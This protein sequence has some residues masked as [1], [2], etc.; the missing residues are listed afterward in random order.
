MSNS[1]RVVIAGGASDADVRN[2]RNV[3]GLGSILFHGTHLPGLPAATGTAT[4]PGVVSRCRAAN[5]SPS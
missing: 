1:P 4:N 2:I 3:G 5:G